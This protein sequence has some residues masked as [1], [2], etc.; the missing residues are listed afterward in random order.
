MDLATIALAVSTANGILTF[1]LRLGTINDRRHI[2][3]RRNTN[4]PP[5]SQEGGP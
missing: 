2:R 4:G 3:G 5:A 1:A